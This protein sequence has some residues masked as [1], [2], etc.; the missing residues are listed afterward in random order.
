M[1]SSAEA[2]VLQGIRVLELG[3]E[4]GGW[5]GK[6]LADMGATVT[7]IEPPEGDPTRA[8]EPF[9]DDQEGV[10][11][12]LY[13]WHYNT[14]KRGVTL[15]LES[16][17][18][19]E[20][21]NELA[22]SADVIVDSLPPG[23][24]DSVDIGYQQIKTISPAVVMASITPFGQD[25][26]FKDYATTDLTALAFGG[27]VW[28]CGYDDHSI[29]PIRGGGNQGYHTACHY[30]AIGI[31][32]ALVHRQFTG[33]GQYI[34]V[35]MHA[36]LNV[37]TEGATYSWLVAGDTVQRQ[38]GR[39]ASVT[40]TAPSQVLCRDGRY[41]NVGFP[42]R[43]EEQWFHLLAWLDEEGLVESLGE[44]LD[45][46]NWAAMRAGDP[47]A[48]E[49]QRRVAE[50]MQSL[51]KKTDSY[52]L[53]SRAQGLGFQWGIIYSPEDVLN[54]PHF[55]ARAFPTEVEHPELD[56]TF[57]YPGAPYKLPASPWAIQSRAPLLGE[58]NE[59]VYTEE[60]GLD[61]SEIKA[62]KSNGVI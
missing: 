20:L 40:P 21:F 10:N 34:D 61:A 1:A 12:S 56:A 57:I 17:R 39:H 48:R 44:Y 51:A 43:T 7:K 55:Q 47:K 60:L 6:L 3:G 9:F 49:Q 36:A 29:P 25:G 45:P 59:Q 16:D 2:S 26:P 52:D 62:L 4:I 54:D 8:Y 30:A 46:P 41:L 27:P 14:S 5:C 33:V 22:E 18:G 50:A 37:T 24:L 32:T 35:N 19:R 23:Y 13:F 42:A 53:F 31:M 15:N 28:N 58:H 11:R 38:T